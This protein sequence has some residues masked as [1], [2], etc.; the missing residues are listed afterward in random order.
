[1]FFKFIRYGF[2]S[3]IL[4]LCCF[5][6]SC[7]SL[8]A[9]EDPVVMLK[10]LS[11]KLQQTISQ[12]DS[13]LKKN[14]EMINDLVKQLITTHMDFVEMSRWAVGRTAWQKA[15]QK[16]QIEF[17]AAFR[18][19]L[20]KTYASALIS[21]K[22]YKIDYKPLREGYESKKRIQVNSLVAIEASANPI[23]ISYRL[24]LEKDSWRVYDIIIEGVSLLQGFQS[25]FTEEL[26]QNGLAGLTHKILDHN[27]KNIKIDNTP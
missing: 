23:S 22:D 19:L 6:W 18:D 4:L 26:H 9:V 27:I 13:D 5:F 3:K 24:L 11:T 1:M 16:D 15:S 10:D 12:H 8:A 17:T 20:I 7:L 2:V 14:P 25:Q 21:Y